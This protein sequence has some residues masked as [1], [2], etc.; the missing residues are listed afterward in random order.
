MLCSQSKFCFLCPASLHEKFHLHP[1]I[2]WITNQILSDIRV[3]IM[4]LTYCPHKIMV[5]KSSW[6]SYLETQNWLLGKYDWGSPRDDNSSVSNSNTYWFWWTAQSP[7]LRKILSLDPSS[8][9]KI[10][11]PL[12]RSVI[13]T[14]WDIHLSI[15]LYI[16]SYLDYIS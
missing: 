10:A 11:D 16:F 7:E 6:R 3:K 2:L 14:E 8:V 5:S 4:N 9:R 1:N 13:G 15:V 12:A